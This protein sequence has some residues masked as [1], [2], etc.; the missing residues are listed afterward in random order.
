MNNKNTIL[1]ISL[2][3]IGIGAFIYISRNKL[4]REL[5]K[6][7]VLCDEEGG[8]LID[9]V[10]YVKKGEEKIVL[11]I[12][13]T[14]E[15]LKYGISERFTYPMSL[16]SKGESVYNL[17]MLIKKQNK[18]ITFI[19]PSIFDEETEKVVVRLLG[20]KSIDSSQDIK[21]LKLKGKMNL[22][23]EMGLK[24]ILA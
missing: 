12:K 1:Y 17:K 7:K 15:Y 4:R 5:A 22:N 6:A 13:Q 20:K 18:N 24:K 11:P 16:G 3:L 2:T 23:N 9:G 21:T 10:C 19:H 14:P 8:E